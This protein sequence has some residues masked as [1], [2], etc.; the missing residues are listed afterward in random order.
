MGAFANKPNYTF[1]LGCWKISKMKMIGSLWTEKFP[2]EK[3]KEI[4]GTPCRFSRSIS[5][6]KNFLS[7]ILNVKWFL[8][9][10]WQTGWCNDK[11]GADL[12]SSQRSLGPKGSRKECLLACKKEGYATGCEYHPDLCSVH[13]GDVGAGSG[14]SPYQCFIFGNARLHWY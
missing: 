7:I 9:I 11:S 4:C 2:N 1:S 10:G 12:I 8:I 5:L 13:T 3:H 14:N 6:P